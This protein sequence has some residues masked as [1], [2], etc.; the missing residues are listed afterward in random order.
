M[1]SLIEFL[2]K[3]FT[4]SKNTKHLIAQTPDEDFIPYSVH[5]DK[6]TIL[7][8][9][10]ELMQIIRIVGFNNTSI[11]AD[12][13]SLRE[14]V[15]DAIRENIKQ[16]NFALWFSTIRRKKNI[17]PKGDFKEFFSKDINQIWEQKNNLQNDFVNELYI[18]VIIEGM[19]TSISNYQS[20]FRSF[21]KIATKKFYNN[22]LAKS[23]KDLSAVTD[24]ILSSISDYGAKI[25]EITEWDGVIYSEPM[26]FLG[27]ICNL[28]E[29]HFPLTVNDI[30]HDLF[31]N[32][33]AIGNREIEIISEDKNYF[34]AILSL[35]EYTEIS[36]ESLDKI[37]QLPFEFIITQSFDFSYSESELD[38][39]KYQDNI[40]RVSKSDDF[41]DLMG[42]TN[43][44]ES[45]NGTNTDYGKLQTTFTIISNSS[46]E[47]AVDV[48]LIV[49]RFQSIG[50]VVVREDVFLED[51][52]WAQLPSNFKFL[53]RQKIINSYR[54]AGFGSLYSFDSGSIS[55]TYWGPALT[56][57]KT[58][59]NTPYFFNF[60]ELDVGH[61]LFIGGVGS[62]KTVLINFLLAQSRRY[63]TKIYYIDFDNKAQ[64]FIEMMGG[65]YYDLAYQD[66][67]DKRCLKINPFALNN[68]DNY[69]KF[70][71]E[72]FRSFI[73]HSVDKIPESEILAIE[74][75][76]EKI[77][78]NKLSN[79]SECIKVFDSEETKNIYEILKFWN[80]GELKRIFDHPKE[81]NW[82]DRMMGFDLTSFR[83]EPF[84]LV[85]ILSYLLFKIE[86]SSNDNSPTII[87]FK[88]SNLLFN[89]SVFIDKIAHILDRLRQKNCVAIFNFDIPNDVEKFDASFLK[90]LDQKITSKFIL[91]KS[92]INK[93][94]AQNISL[95]DEEFRITKYLK[96]EDYRFL[97]KRGEDSLVLNF[98][99]INHKPLMRLLSSTKDDVAI[100]E[101]I[102]NHAKEQG[103][104]IDNE[105]A[106]KQFNEVIN[107]LEH[108]RL[109]EQKKIDRQSKIA[110][111]KKLRE[112]DDK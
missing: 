56:T 96:I 70:L 16:T 107:I 92:N 78:T 59:N 30:S 21:S 5:Y 44:F 15:R 98:D 25:L 38:F 76:V 88:D 52:F 33:M 22:F 101:E 85:P 41:R 91:P 17:S 51:C 63:N 18:T 40:L 31:F 109:E 103:K 94:L 71:I 102:F 1:K 110:R 86:A 74:K 8:K 3:Y 111:M 81:I 46:E 69:K 47:L 89:N 84:V 37:L 106:I 50:L 49:E 77:I 4:L 57:F 58:I 83:S 75:I 45:V 20:F 6:K 100:L 39:L 72:F 95:N 14:A 112:I 68:S 82:S 13:I 93:E 12:L 66:P 32:K 64:N 19:D 9:N 80:E 73:Y 36:I 54:I 2:V 7:T 67:S 26:R 43:F 10:G 55:G 42:V 90:L 105:I 23:C 35:K 34:S 61:A 65:F 79:F 28:E 53:K 11:F 108:E 24:G 29:R 60:H 87:V 97:L 27:K 104:I 62:G 99:L 48:K